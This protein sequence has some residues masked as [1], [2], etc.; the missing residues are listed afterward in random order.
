M[1]ARGELI[2]RLREDVMRAIAHHEH[3]V[4]GPRLADIEERLISYGW[5]HSD[6]PDFRGGTAFGRAID[7]SLQKLKR[8]G[9][10]RYEGRG[11]RLSARR[12]S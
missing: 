3:A 11:W 1:R 12:A 4:A 2:E 8:D 10:I 9:R 7:R 5:R 6:W